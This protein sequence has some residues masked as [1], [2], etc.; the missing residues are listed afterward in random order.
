MEPIRIGERRYSIQVEIH[1]KA[2]SPLEAL[3][4]T[5]FAIE[6]IDGY[7]GYDRVKIDEVC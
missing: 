4:K 3:G 6:K 1:V 2:D 5:Q 7:K